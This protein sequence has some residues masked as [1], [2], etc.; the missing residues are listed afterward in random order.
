MEEKKTLQDV[1]G[2]YTSGE[3]GLDDTNKA[4]KE[5][6]SSLQLDPSRNMF[7]AEE[8]LD[9]PAEANG[10]GIMDHGV[11]CMEKVRIVDGICVS[12]DMGEEIAYVYIGG[13]KYRLRG[14]VLTE[15]D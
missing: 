3:T 15:E 2:D 8:L 10:W 12:C 13:R 6:G 5:M 4:L 11:G 1:L 9:T 14:T 7:T